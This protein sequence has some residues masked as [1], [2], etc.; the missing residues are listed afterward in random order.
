MDFDLGTL[1]TVGAFATV[2]SGVI[3]LFSWAQN[4]RFASLGWWGAGL[5]VLAVGYAIM[6]ARGSLPLKMS[7]VIGSGLCLLANGFMWCGARAFADRSIRLMPAVAGA[8]VW[9]VVCQFDAIAMSVTLRQQLFSLITVVYTGL[10]AWEYAHGGDCELVSRWPAVLLLVVHAVLFAARA[11]FPYKTIFPNVATHQ[12]NLWL[13]V[14]AAVLLAHYL[15]MAFLVLS[16]AKEHLELEYRRAARIDALTGI[17]NRRAFFEGAEPLL[18]RTL[19]SGQPVALLVLDLDLFKS[20][21]DTF[22]HQA[23]DRVLRVFCDA[24]V[25]LLRP[26]DLFGRTGGEEFA[27]LLPQTSG[28]AA[29]R[30]AERIRSTFADRQVDLGGARVTATVSVGVAAARGGDDL[31]SLMAAADHALYGAKAAGRNRVF[32]ADSLMPRIDVGVA[33]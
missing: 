16:M 8:L 7:I 9:V 21:N 26:A 4:R 25:A 2:I 24:V 28:V 5:I 33:A 29:M 11:A 20:I 14:L 22:G 12:M 6:T 32:G 10:A 23:G 30:I 1:V 31:A 27:L 18:R 19:A 13:T 15:S 3:L 17:A